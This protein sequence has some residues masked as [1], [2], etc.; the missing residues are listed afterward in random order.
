[1][2]TCPFFVGT[3]A[4]GAGG[5]AMTELSVVLVHTQVL[6]GHLLKENEKTEEFVRGQLW[7]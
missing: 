4:T 7:L 3:V 2:G 1:M 5:A 6:R